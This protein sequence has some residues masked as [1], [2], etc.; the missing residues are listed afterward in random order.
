MISARYK[1]FIPGFI[2]VSWLYWNMVKK[3]PSNR[4]EVRPERVLSPEDFCVGNLLCIAPH[5]D[6]AVIGAYFL[7][8]FWKRQR[9]GKCIVLNLS[10]GESSMACA[11]LPIQ[12]AVKIRKQAYQAAENQ[13]PADETKWGNYTFTN[14]ENIDIDSNL[15]EIIG[16]ALDEFRPVAVAVTHWEDDHPDHRKS[17]EALA[18]ILQKEPLTGC[19]ILTYEINSHFTANARIARDS[20]LLE[21]KCSCIYEIETVKK[22]LGGT[23]YDWRPYFK[24]LSLYRSGEAYRL[25]DATDFTKQIYGK[26]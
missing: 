7:M 13:V 9:I 4:E 8:S 18:E 2:E 22:R 14:T 10:A 6:D 24:A 19:K 21:K 16:S 20:N 5:P 17:A 26:D 12:E 15:K 3:G 25:S 11:H 1:K 23:F